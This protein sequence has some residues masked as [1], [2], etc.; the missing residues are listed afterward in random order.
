MLAQDSLPRGSGEA[1]SLD[2]L[3][4]QAGAVVCNAI[5][6]ELRNCLG[7]AFP[8]AT[9][10]S[11]AVIDPSD[12]AFATPLRPLGPPFDKAFAYQMRQRHGW[13]FGEFDG[14]Y[15][16]LVAVPQSRAVCEIQAID[17]LLKAAVTV[18]AIGPVPV[19]QLP[20][21][22]RGAE[23]LLD[24]DS[25]AALLGH[26]VK[27]DALVLLSDVSSLAIDYGKPEQQQIRQATP[28]ML[29]ALQFDENSMLT[30]VEAASAFVT[31]TGHWAAIGDLADVARIVIGEAGTRIVPSMSGPIEMWSQ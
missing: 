26:E 8:I 24:T 17:A 31:S 18:V 20:S 23:A 28:T 12:P 19:I 2:E 11:Q 6:R 25:F 3:C 21:G 29:E 10:L 7:P 1:S 15:R 16:R 27:A 5:E 22:M 13:D 9:I 4:A 14:Q 30:K